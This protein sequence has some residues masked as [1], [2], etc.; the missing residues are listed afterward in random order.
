MTWTRRI[1]WVPDRD[2]KSDF[3]TSYNSTYTTYTSSKQTQLFSSNWSEPLD[4]MNITRLKV[5]SESSLV[6]VSL[7][8]QP[9][10][11]CPCLSVMSICLAV[12]PHGKTFGWT[13][14]DSLTNGENDL[15]ERGAPLLPFCPLFKGSNFNHM[16][17]ITI[18]SQRQHRA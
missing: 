11:G 7:G 16:T 17:V 5:T 15:S 12:Q 13:R 2:R 6:R 14:A 1:G 18:R 4:K 9:G 3:G 8:S 10:E